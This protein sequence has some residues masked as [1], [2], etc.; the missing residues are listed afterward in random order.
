MAGKYDLGT[1]LSYNYDQLRINEFRNMVSILPRALR[2]STNAPYV[3]FVID[4]TTF[5][6]YTNQDY[7]MQM[8]L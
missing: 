8:S 3:E 7:F 1:Y 2:G 4:G 5:A 6:T